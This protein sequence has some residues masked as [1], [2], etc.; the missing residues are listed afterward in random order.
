MLN[1]IKQQQLFSYMYTVITDVFNG[2]WKIL[3]FLCEMISLIWEGFK[4]K[5]CETTQ[6]RIFLSNKS[7]EKFI[8]IHIFLLHIFSQY[9]SLTA[10]AG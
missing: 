10:S 5:F 2:P 1:R 8:Q 4:T 6:Q 7:N 3:G 9:A